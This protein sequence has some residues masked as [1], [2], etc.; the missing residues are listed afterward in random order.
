VLFDACLHPWGLNDQ[1]LETLTLFGVKA[2]VAVSWATAASPKGIRA[3]FDDLLDVQLPRLKRAGI[4]G[5]AALGVHPSGLPR[6]G[7]SEVLAALPGYC[8]AGKVVAIGAL[9]LRDGNA[10][11]EEALLEQLD[12]AKRLK[13]RA[14]VVVPKVSSD[15]VLRKTLRLLKHS[16]L[17][18]RRALV[19]GVDAKGLNAVR[20]R[21][22][23]AGLLLHPDYLSVEA[24]VA[25]LRRNGSEGVLL[26]SGSGRTASDFLALA[27]AQ[28]VMERQQVSAHFAAHVLADNAAAFFRVHV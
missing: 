16:G 4:R 17:P 21:G 9:G 1:D 15:S 20:E 10:S 22:H 12:L 27:R 5:Y 6:R 28:S 25:L 19:M 2:A 18:E 24:A 14:L 7:L 8:R 3:H 23:H 11:E 26:G 13:L